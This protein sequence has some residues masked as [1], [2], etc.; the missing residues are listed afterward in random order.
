MQQEVRSRQGACWATAY[1]EQ[2]HVDELDDKE[3]QPDLL[4]VRENGN[5]ADDEHQQAENDH[6][7]AG[8]SDGALVGDVND[9]HN[10]QDHKVKENI[11]S[12]KRYLARLYG[13]IDSFP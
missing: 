4:E 3:N 12:V 6:V 8:R 9:A 13:C 2:G 10:E 11:N 5:A 7:H 1:Q